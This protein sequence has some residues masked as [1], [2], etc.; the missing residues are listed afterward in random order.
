MTIPYM[1]VSDRVVS[2]DPTGRALVR[3]WRDVPLAQL[4]V[5]ARSLAMLN[6]RTH[7]PHDVWSEFV[8][9]RLELLRWGIR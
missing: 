4:C 3:G 2:I 8:M 6:Q 5:R 9:M 1:P 7:L